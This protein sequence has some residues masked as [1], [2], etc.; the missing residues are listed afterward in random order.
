MFT[1]FTLDRGTALSLRFELRCSPSSPYIDCSCLARGFVCSQSSGALRQRCLP[2]SC[3]S[4]V[5]EFLR[6][7]LRRRATRPHIYVHVTH[8]CAASAHFTER[9]LAEVTTGPTR[10]IAFLSDRRR[11]DTGA[12]SF[13]SIFYRY[14]EIQGAAAARAA[15]FSKFEPH[16]LNLHFEI[17]TH[18]RS[19]RYT[20]RPYDWC[21]HCRLH[22]TPNGVFRR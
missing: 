9:S 2:R 12:D 4:A 19:T 13:R 21:R 7:Q 18:S 3:D 8:V 10:C 11:G 15:F 6:S 5:R 17:L 22:S 1:K 14:F 16:G 20:A